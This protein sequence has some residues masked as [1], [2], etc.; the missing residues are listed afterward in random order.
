[1]VFECD[2]GATRV[3]VP[4][5]VEVSSAPADL[6]WQS[7]ALFDTALADDGARLSAMPWTSAAAG[8]PE[9][10]AARIVQDG[11]TTV[12]VEASAPR[13]GIL[14]LRDSYDPSWTAEV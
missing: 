14:V 11:A 6:T 12:V 5:S 13:A 8:A 10:T 1:R 2:P 3:F 4:S 9:P 7:D